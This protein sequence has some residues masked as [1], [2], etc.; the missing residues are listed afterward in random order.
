[1]F[2]S[3]LT[4]YKLYANKNLFKSCPNRAFKPETTTDNTTQTQQN[5]SFKTCEMTSSNK[6]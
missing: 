5:L 4:T 3:D 2:F 1:M 6:H